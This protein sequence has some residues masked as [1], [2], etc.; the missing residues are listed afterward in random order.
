MGGPRPQSRIA[1]FINTGAI[2]WHTRLC[3]SHQHWSGVV[4]V[5]QIDAMGFLWDRSS[6]SCVGPSAPPLNIL[7]LA[8]PTSIVLSGS[9]CAQSDFA[10]LISHMYKKYVL[11]KHAHKCACHLLAC[12]MS[13]HAGAIDPSRRTAVVVGVAEK[14]CAEAAKKAATKGTPKAKGAAAKRGKGKRAA[15]AVKA[16][17]EEGEEV[18]QEEEAGQAKGLRTFWA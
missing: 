4:W 15:S 3:M 7:P 13:V 18:P 11:I 6:S 2:K 1:C 12:A 16:E 9:R 10:V 5:E 17:G 8:D 14:I